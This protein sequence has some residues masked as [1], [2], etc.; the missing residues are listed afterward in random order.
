MDALVA[1]LMDRIGLSEPQARG[2]LVIVLTFLEQEAPPDL[3]ARLLA[4]MPGARDLMGARADNPPVPEGTRHFGGVARLMRVADR[5]MAL[6]LTMTQVQAT[7]RDVL[8]F[9]RQEAGPATVDGI[10]IAIP[11]LRQV[12]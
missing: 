7:V 10:V 11:G 6:G 5:M 8:D 9:A 1:R 3:L 4:H 2:A 12:L